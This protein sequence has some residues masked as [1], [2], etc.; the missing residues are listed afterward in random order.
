M[1]PGQHG[2]GSPTE[3]PDCEEDDKQRG[4]EHHLP[5]IGGS[6]PDSQGKRHSSP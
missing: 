1:Q 3:Y 5:G 6:V 2:C 4:G